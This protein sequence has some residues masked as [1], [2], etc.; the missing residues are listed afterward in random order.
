MP[1]EFMV[2]TKYPITEVTR[3]NY[4]GETSYYIRV[5]IRLV[6]SGKFPFPN[7]QPLLISIESKDKI[8][9]TPIK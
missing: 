6:K 7:M 9:I 4:V 3:L 2:N 1:C 5:P 8:V